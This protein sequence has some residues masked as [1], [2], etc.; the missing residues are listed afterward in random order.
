IGSAG[1]AEKVALLTEKYGYDAAFNYKDGVQDGPAEPGLPSVTVEL[2]RAELAGGGAARGRAASAVATAVAPDLVAHVQTAADGA[3]AFTGLTAGA[4]AVRVRYPESLAV[5]WD[6]EGLFDASAQVLVPESGEAQAQVG[7]AGD[8]RADLRVRT[9]SGGPVSG[10]VLLWWAG[11]DGTF[12]T[13]DDVRVPVEAVDGRVVVDGL[14]AGDY[15]VVG[16]DGVA[17]SPTLALTAEVRSSTVTLGA[18]PAAAPVA[19]PA[20]AATGSAGAALLVTACWLVAGGLV[21]AR[22]GRAARRSR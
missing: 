21:L 2:Y 18:D 1:S 14:P 16:P 11:P 19:A 12:G 10:T 7:L 6:S 15:R 22:V 9:P 13:A 8:A 17:V 20:L 5:T 3:F 4:Y